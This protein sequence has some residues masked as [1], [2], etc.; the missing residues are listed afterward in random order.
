MA[1]PMEDE[2][3]FNCD[4][5]G[6]QTRRFP[7]GHYWCLCQCLRQWPEEPGGNEPLFSSPCPLCAE[8]HQRAGCTNGC[9]FWLGGKCKFGAD[10]QNCHVH[11]CAALPSAS[12]RPAKAER[13]QIN[14]LQQQLTQKEEEL[15]VV[16]RYWQEHGVVPPPEL[17]RP[18]CESIPSKTSG[19][20]PVGFFYA[21]RISIKVSNPKGRLRSNIVSLARKAAAECW[22]QV[23]FVGNSRESLVINAYSLPHW[24]AV[25]A[26]NVSRLGQTLGTFA[27]AP[28]CMDRIKDCLAYRRVQDTLGF[29]AMGQFKKMEVPVSSPVPDG[30]G[31]GS[32]FGPSS[33]TRS[34][35]EV[36]VLEAL[37]ALHDPDSVAFRDAC[38]FFALRCPIKRLNDIHTFLKGGEDSAWRELEAER[39]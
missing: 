35:G 21:I 2:R 39:V 16:Y 4:I 17:H 33:V 14:D 20:P 27:I 23:Y 6:E 3:C 18:L 30:T 28:D 5:E 34:E 7:C 25:F 12:R 19:Q 13:K 29:L 37:P 26:D 24:L 1:S 8:K 15:D 32:S 10:C 22:G 36:R 31:G 11:E 38:K 9:K